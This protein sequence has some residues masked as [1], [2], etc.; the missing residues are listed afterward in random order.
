MPSLSSPRLARTLNP[1]RSLRARIALAFAALTLLSVVAGSAIEARRERLQLEAAAGR[2]LVEFAETLADLIG[3]DLDSGLT[4]LKVMASLPLF[5]DRDWFGGEA[6]RASAR[7][8]MFTNL[9]QARPVFAWVA[10]VDPEG[11]V[12]AASRGHRLGESVAGAAWFAAARQGPHVGGLHAVPALERLL[13]GTPAGSAHYVDIAMPVV[14]EDGRDGGVLVMHFSL[15]WARALR[16]RLL[17]SPDRPPGADLLV[18]DRA[19]TVVIGPAGSEGTQLAEPWVPRPRPRDEAFTSGTW[20]DGRTYLVGV[21]A[22]PGLG[23]RV[24]ARQDADAA[25]APVAA[26]YLRTGLQAAVLALACGLLGWWLAGR[27]AAPLR[28]ITDAARRIRQ[29]EPTDI[30]LAAHGDEIAEL[31]RTLRDTMHGLEARRQELADELAE[32]ARVQAKLEQ[33]E[34]R[35]E[36]ALEGANLALWD[37]DLDAGTI[38]LSEQWMRMLGERPAPAVTNLEEV[39]ERVHPEDRPRMQQAARDVVKGVIPEYHEEYR[40]RSAA[41][42]WVWVQSRGKV[43]AR[44]EHGRALRMTG[45]NADVTQRRQAEQRIQYLATRDALTD[46]PNTALLTDRIEQAIAAAQ[47]DK[48][49]VALLYVDLDRFKNT[50]DSLGQRVGDALLRAVAGR[51]KVVLRKEDSLGRH[52]GDEFIALLPSL[53]GQREAASIAYKILAALGRPFEIEGHALHVSASIGI[54]MYPSDGRDAATLLKSA[55][56]AM[57]HAKDAGGNKAQ[58]F[59]ARMRELA[60]HRHLIE[61]HLRT[62][63]ANDELALNYQPLFDLTTEQAVGV[64]ALLRWNNPTL[65]PVPPRDFIPVAED[66]GLI[67]PIGQWVLAEACRQTRRWHDAGHRDLRVAVNVSVRQFRR[68]GFC[69]VVQS[70]LAHSGLSPRHLELEI[71]ESVLMEHSQKSIAELEALGGLGVRLCI[72]DFGTGYSGLSYLKRLPVHRLKI[73]QSFVRDIARDPNDAAIVSA[74]IALSRSLGLKVT[75]EGVETDAQMR[76][77]LGHACNEAQG[78]YFSAPVPAEQVERVLA[79][80][81]AQRMLRQA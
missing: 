52:G 45:T 7:A 23:W 77:L 36:R 13:G 31:A 62:A 27:I 34:E 69:D 46:L 33:S 67:V 63:L 61:T 48:T 9:A 47:R 1:R 76:F 51:L 38:Y 12:V 5:R 72:D 14:T 73:D 80:R 59:A 44:D 18:I 71:T 58:F 43:V 65:G 78:Y 6:R 54:A 3:R 21:A 19:G 57:Y 4:E 68:K 8:E 25:L 10:L 16:Q 60:Q 79:P 50:N 26:S 17:A 39:Y 70:A 42:Q 41:G 2:A 74:V 75:A 20:S 24:V 37:A 35:L 32:R 28:A 81:G 15:A 30:P 11:R 66:S 56:T 22:E 40:I 55:D 29:G 49:W 53:S 64:E